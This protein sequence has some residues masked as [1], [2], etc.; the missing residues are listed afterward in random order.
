MTIKWKLLLFFENDNS[1]YRLLLLLICICSPM[2]HFLF[3]QYNSHPFWP[4]SITVLL[5]VTT[6]LIPWFSKSKWLYWI[7]LS[8]TVTAFLIFQNGYLLIFNS[9]QDVYVFRGFTLFLVLNTFYQKKWEFAAYIL[10]NAAIISYSYYS[11]PHPYLSPLQIAIVLLGFA[12]GSL[13]VYVIKEAYRYYFKKAVDNVM[14]LNRTLIKNEELLL[15]NRKELYALISSINDIIFEF[16]EKKVCLNVWDNG[17]TAGY[18]DTKAY[19]G[20]TLDEVLGNHRARQ[21][22][23]AIEDVIASHQPTALEFPSLFGKGRWFSA[24]LTPVYDTAGNYTGRISGAVTDITAQK[25]HAAVLR[26]NG[27]LLTEAQRIAKLGNWWYELATK[28]AFWST[29][30]YQILEV[31]QLPVNQTRFEYYI[32]LVH[33][34]DRKAAHDFFHNIHLN[35]PGQFEHRFVTPQGN[36]KFLKVISGQPVTDQHG[37]LKRVIGVIQD[38]TEAKLAEK[39]IKKNSAE[40]LE[41][42]TIA[43]IGN[44]K[45]NT[46]TGALSWSDEVFRIYGVQIKPARRSGYFK[47]LF[48]YTHPD[49]RA[50]LLNVIRDAAR[51]EGS[52]YEYRIVTPSGQKK[53]LSIITGKVMHREDGAVRKIIGTIQDITE[54]KQADLARAQSENK[55]RL[56]L[57]TVKLAAVSLDRNGKIIFCN[58]HLADLLGFTQHELLGLRWMD[59]FVPKRERALLNNWFE[60]HTIEDNYVNPIICRTG[61]E[62]IISWQNTATY[63]EQGHLVETTSIGEDITDQQKD[64]QQLIS[65]KEEAE[66]LS[67]Y[68]S[69][70]LS[71]MSHEIRTPMNAVIGTTNL[72][73]SEDP[74]PHQL[75]YLNTL[76]FS[77]ENL[78]A[79]INDIL[80]FNRIEAGKL[81]LNKLPFNIDDLINK[82]LNTFYSRAAEKGLAIE[83]INEGGT[84]GDL[85]GDVIRL[86]Q[87]IN[88]LLSN[89]VKFTH[90][91]KIVIQ[92]RK[93]DTGNGT[94]QVEFVI[95]DTGIGIAPENLDKIFDPFIQETL[96]IHSMYGGSGLGLAITKRLVEMHGSNITVKSEPGH[97]AAFMFSILFE[98]SLTARK[99]DT[100]VQQGNVKGMRVLVV[101]DNQMNILIATKFLKKWEAEVHHAINGRIA[102]EKA[103]LTDYDLIIMDLQMPLMN[104][105]EATS[106]IKANKPYLNIIALTADAMPETFNKAL[107]AGMDGYLTKPFV[108]EQLFEMVVKYYRRPVI[109]TE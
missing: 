20:K 66:R 61:E 109:E 13:F 106:I 18:V 53:F 80:D 19:I 41:A 6:V 100:V 79:I 32:G 24:R 44:W 86:S 62:R 39:T 64:R 5:G 37:A 81:S 35:G 16:D 54:R 25:K 2:L 89:A 65:A 57:E 29:N 49:D 10:L 84:S 93:Q 90:T 91:G 56:V 45:W 3:P 46:D 59:S 55:Y 48:R 33:P 69:E 75:E 22:N 36:T 101:D 74:L 105:F 70:F 31:D 28:E 77:G 50:G 8:L 104:G 40:L 23:L 34:D 17:H 60:N 51:N 21:F 85:V 73:L 52:S 9:F 71:V 38:I 83:L 15:E 68:K 47:I 26:E 58:K 12:G 14:Q 98:K 27:A 72:L 103:L 78:L 7:S 30:L 43:K 92:L 82:I 1:V 94:V 95:K 108:P 97:G 99:S 88:N 102:V 11:T 63:D 4:H 96:H 42:Q 87:I 107:S 76:K 67:E